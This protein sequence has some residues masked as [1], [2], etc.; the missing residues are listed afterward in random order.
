MSAPIV[1]PFNFEPV[2]TLVTGA[3]YTVPAGQYARAVISNY[4]GTLA[5]NSSLFSVKTPHPTTYQS[6]STTGNF[7]TTETTFMTSTI[8]GRV[9]I[10]FSTSYLGIATFRWRRAGNVLFM[11]DLSASDGYTS[12]ITI[13]GKVITG[14]T[15]TTRTSLATTAV[16]S[17]SLRGYSDYEPEVFDFWLKAGDVITIG[18]FS[19]D[20]KMNLMLYNKIS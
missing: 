17:V 16:R 14:D 1:V 12:S 5:I 4:A 13:Q 20:V 8:D 15:F 6:A 11:V 2:S 19:P 7:G 3:N 10:N 9:N 18:G